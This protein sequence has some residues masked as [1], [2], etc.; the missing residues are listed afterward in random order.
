MPGPKHVP[1]RT[2][3]GCRK[4]CP[5]PELVRL[6]LT[7]A[8]MAVALAGSMGG[9]GAWLHPSAECARSAIK[10]RAFSRAFRKN[11]DFPTTDDLI[12][13]VLSAAQPRP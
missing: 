7:G 13:A 6:V 5:A 4:V 1:A 12:A 11:L 2:C 9:R 10:T 3:V 8:G